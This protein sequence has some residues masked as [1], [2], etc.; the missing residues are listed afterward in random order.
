MKACLSYAKK[1][2]G[3]YGVWGGQWFDGSGY[4]PFIPIVRKGAMQ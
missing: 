2:N 4:I 3:S 1:Q